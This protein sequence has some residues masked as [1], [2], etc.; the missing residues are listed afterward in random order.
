MNVCLF[1]A[2]FSGGAT[3]RE[4][5][6]LVGGA[7]SGRDSAVDSAGMSIALGRFP[8]KEQRVGHRFSESEW[9]CNRTGRNIAVSAQRERVSLPVVHKRC[10]D[11]PF[12]QRRI[13]LQSIG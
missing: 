7:V 5:E 8:A 3:R 12:Q 6:Y 4:F 1:V 2:I 11:S 10:D 13:H 9:R